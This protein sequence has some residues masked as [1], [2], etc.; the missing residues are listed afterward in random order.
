M[1]MS[2]IYFFIFLLSCMLG[3]VVGLGGGVIIRP[4]LDAIG[5]HGV[6]NIG[7]LSSSAILVMAVVSTAKKVQDGTKIDVSTAVLISFGALVGGALGN[8]LLDYATALFYYLHGTETLVQLIQTVF[9]IVILTLA[10]YFTTSERFR[11][12]MKTK[13]LYPFL[14]LILGGAAVFLGIGGGPINVPVFMVLFSLPAKQATAYSIVVI[15][16]SHLFRIIDMGL[17][18]YHL[19][20]AGFAIDF[21]P[22]I[23]PAAL[24]GGVAGAVISK[25]FSDETV[26]KMFNVTMFVLILINVYNGVMFLL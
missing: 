20:F 4:I 6:M 7:F 15:F 5:Y 12:N 11:Y 10:I 23:L 9:T 3:A 2:I 25:R 26:K 1:L 16:F 19:G 18:G 8:Q 24:I 14:G 22:F 21:L 17:G 13:I